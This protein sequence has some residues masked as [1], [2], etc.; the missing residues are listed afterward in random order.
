MST[1]TCQKDEWSEG[2]RGCVQT[3]TCDTPPLH[4]HQILLLLELPIHVL[5]LL[6]HHDHNHNHN[7]NLLFLRFVLCFVLLLLLLHHVPSRRHA[8]Q[9]KTEE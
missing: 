6:L 9:A 7:H 3:G 1:F 2:E 4:F 5:P 8:A